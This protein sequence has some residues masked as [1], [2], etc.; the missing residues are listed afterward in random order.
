MILVGGEGTRLRPLTADTPKPM[1]PLAGRPLLAYT[2]DHLR[3][4]GVH[5]AVLSC[6]YLPTQIEEHFGAETGGLALD[7]RV[8]PQ[9]LGTGGAIRFGAEGITDTFLALNGDSL[10]AADLDTLIAFHRERG[11]RATIL[12]T[13]VAD[14]TRYGLVR[15][16][17]NGL[18]SGFL[19]KPRPEEID[20]DLINAGLYVL[21]PDV[22]DLIPSDKAVSIEREV[23]PRLVEEGSLYGLALPGYW[24][25]VG[26]PESYLQAHRDVLERNVETEVGDAL[27]ADYV[28][29]DPSAQVSPHARLVP[30]VLNGAGAAI[31]AGARVGSLAV[32]GAGARIGEG[33]VVEDAVVGE[34]ATVGE[35]AHVVGSLLG[36][37]SEVA[38]ECVVRGLSVVG[39][40]ARIGAGNMLDH[41]LRVGA[42][43]T[44]PPG[45][46][47][48]S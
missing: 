13:P 43:E 11:A 32:V 12:L 14:P 16:G 1:L 9:P 38:A 35:S 36:E 19:E 17:E 29:I 48:F 28:S 44:I 42:G 25:D 45:A 8:E 23:F 27:G 46:L 21:E 26:T 40:R 24:L 15:L 6:G 3:R 37:G 22:L 31:A 2:F 30:P 41:G 47:T 10:R 39:P 20:T 5:R 18:V 34:G 7:Y 4:H 33:A